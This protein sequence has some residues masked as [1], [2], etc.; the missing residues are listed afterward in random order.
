M[1]KVRESLVA[2]PILVVWGPYAKHTVSP[3]GEGAGGCWMGG[4]G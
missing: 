3:A 4:L 1:L 2:V